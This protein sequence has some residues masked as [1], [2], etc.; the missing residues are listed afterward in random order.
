MT[1]KEGGW[2]AGECGAIDTTAPK[3]SEHLSQYGRN[4]QQFNLRP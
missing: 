2:A 4:K 1:K 3:R